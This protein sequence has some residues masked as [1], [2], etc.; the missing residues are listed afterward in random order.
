MKEITLKIPD[1]KMEF[2][3]QLIRELGFEV[4]DVTEIPEEQ[5]EE[6]KTRLELIDSVK[7]ST[8]SWKE[9]EKEI[10]LNS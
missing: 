1:K 10:F 6:V 8:R 5:Q 7:M 2:F 4:H 3:L 9:A